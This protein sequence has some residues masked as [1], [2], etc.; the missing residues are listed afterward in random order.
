MAE[1]P[2]TRT[3]K[4]RRRPLSSSRA[5]VYARLAPRFALDESGPTL[6]FDQVFG[7]QVFGD[8]VFGDQVFGVHAQV[9]LDIGIGIGDVMIAMALAQPELK[10]VGCDVHTP[11]IA[12][13]LAS[14][15]EHGLDNVRVVHGDALQFIDRL[16]PAA[17]T[18]V[19]IFFPDPWPKIRQRHRRL[20]RADVVDRLVALL[21]VGGWLHLAT[22]IA[23][24]AEQ[25]ER[26][27][28]SHPGLAGGVIERPL[29]RPVTRYE[30]KGLDA[31][32]TATDFWYERVPTP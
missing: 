12:A 24:Y 23:D 6:D 10:V 20:V 19:R 18:G 2:P 21:R 11:G 14:I 29:T 22:D 16:Q 27:C 5:E 1:R 15:E 4:P 17:L 30:Q 31:G 9:V 3:F 25:I 13:V 32:R 8:Q 7:D 28:G 26:V